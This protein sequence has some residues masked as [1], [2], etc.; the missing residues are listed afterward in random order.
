MPRGNFVYQE[1]EATA[2][3]YTLKRAGRVKLFLEI[4]V[5]LELFD[6]FKVSFSV[7]GVT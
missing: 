6:V 4:Q 1:E 3:S 2:T 5:L 7:L